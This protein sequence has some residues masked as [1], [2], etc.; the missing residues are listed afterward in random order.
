M[1]F[2][3]LLVLAITLASSPARAAEGDADHGPFGIGL[4]VGQ[5]TGLTMEL[6][7]SEHTAIDAAVGLDLFDE[8][9]FYFHLEFL[10]F[11]PT[12]VTADSL[13][14]AAY[15]GVGGFIVDH[16]DRLGLGVRAP[17]GLSLE[18]TAVPLEIFLEIAL[19]VRL[20]PDGPDFDPGAA[21][22]FRYYF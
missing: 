21:L 5:P 8:R 12:L 4:V 10:Y 14:L 1:R 9:R 16:P 6:E 2:A 22:G 13:S 19:H 18:F 17:F 7:L 15:L 20:V 11:L 3:C